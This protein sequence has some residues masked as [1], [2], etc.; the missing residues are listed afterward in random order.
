MITVKAPAKINLTLEVLGKR[1]DGYHEVRS[2][3]QAIDLCDTLRFTEAGDTSITCDMPEW[4]A[5]ESLVSRA[6]N[7]LAEISG[8]GKGVKISMEKRIP[9]HSGLGGDSSDAA[10]ILKGLNEFWQ[11]NLSR[12]KLLSLAARLGSDVPFFI[13]GGT[14]LV[15]GRG[16]VI[17]PLNSPA[18][19]WAVLVFPDIPVEAGKT[20]RM[21]AALKPSHFTDGSI[22]Q[23]LIDNLNNLEPSLL[24][25]TFENVAFSIFPGLDVYKGHLIKLGAPRVHL[26]GS[27]L[28][29]FA[30]FRQKSIAEDLYTRCKDQGMKTCL[31]QTI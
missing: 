7:L 4:S 15:S 23:R 13:E 20:G 26:A 22:T 14:A 6:V 21:Y 17:R 25:N 27:G 10:A 30:L 9:L 24:F 16:E 19:M 1:P 12:E 3:V 2:I 31:A 5:E 8:P 28:T 29:L 18:G 11:L